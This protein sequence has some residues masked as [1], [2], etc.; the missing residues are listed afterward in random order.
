M[1]A[2]IETFLGQTLFLFLKSRRPGTRRWITGLLMLERY[3]G[4]CGQWKNLCLWIDTCRVCL[5]D[6]WISMEPRHEHVE[7]ANMV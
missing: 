3:A 4:V 7:I 1:N 5:L 2:M 6:C